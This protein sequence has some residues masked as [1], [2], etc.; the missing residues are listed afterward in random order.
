MSR[1]KR[2]IAGM[3]QTVYDLVWIIA[4]VEYMRAKDSNE[5]CFAL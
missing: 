2:G 5:F 1:D 4:D 3:T